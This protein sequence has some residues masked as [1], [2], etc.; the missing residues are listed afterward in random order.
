MKSWRWERVKQVQRGRGEEG[1]LTRAEDP[2]QGIVGLGR[3]VKLG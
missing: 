3:M 1:E 2:C